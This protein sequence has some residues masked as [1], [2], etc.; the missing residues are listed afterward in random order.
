M[1]KLDDKLIVALDVDSLKKAENFV[2]T[3]FPK[4]KIFKVGSQLFTAC[5]PQAVNMIQKKGA[6]VFLDLK[7]HD[8]P[9]TVKNAVEIATSLKVF[10][11]TLHISGGREMLEAIANIPGRPLV[12]GVTVLTSSNENDAEHSV[13][14]LARLAKNSGLD[15]VV[16]SVHEAAMVRKECGRDFII[17]TPGIRLARLHCGGAGSKTL[18]DQKRTATA[19][20]AIEAGADYIVVGRPILESK[21]PLLIAQEIIGEAYG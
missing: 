20:E 17:V 2:G 14:S 18:D 3:L 15:G 1:Q 19:K 7:F 9:N 8:I 4:V 12:V 6:K 5:G 10:M 11:L 16:C 13:L 21:N